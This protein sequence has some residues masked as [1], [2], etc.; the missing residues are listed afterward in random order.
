MICHKMKSL[1]FT[2]T[3]T[4]HIIAISGL[5]TGILSGLIIF[6]MGKINKIYKLN[7]FIY[8]DVYLLNYGW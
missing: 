3:G 1:M 8:Y 6:M 2:R 5:H 4:S 7:G